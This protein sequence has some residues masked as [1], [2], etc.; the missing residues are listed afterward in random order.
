[1]ELR[2]AAP[3][4]WQP[5]LVALAEYASSMQGEMVRAAPEMLMKAQGM[6]VAANEISSILINAPKLQDEFAQ[7]T[8]RAAQRR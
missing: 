8:M 6:A 3:H 5:F 7:A 2:A 4:Q 1:M